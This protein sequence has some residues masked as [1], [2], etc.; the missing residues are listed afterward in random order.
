MLSGL[1]TVIVGRAVFGAKI[2]TGGAWRRA[3]GRLLPLIGI[4][5]L[6]GIGFSLLVVIA[7]MLAFG[8]GYV[9]GGAAAVIAGL[10]LAGMLFLLFVYVSTILLFAP[11]LIVLERLSIV[12][13]HCAV[14]R[15]G[16]R[17]LL[18]GAGHLVSRNV[19]RGAYRVGRIRTI[20]PG[21]RSDVGAERIHDPQR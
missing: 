17:G 3:R 21:R 11:A 15:P 20:Q 5:L 18:A 12:S 6:Q 7:T 16:T 19:R 14:L 13:S 1:L 8:I 2:T 4:T 9:A 10:L